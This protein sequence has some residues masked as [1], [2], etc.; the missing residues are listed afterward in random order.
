MKSI[1]TT[2]FYIVLISEP[3]PSKSS[4]MALSRKIS[5]SSIHVDLFILFHSGSGQLDRTGT[6]AE[7]DAQKK[8]AISEWPL[9]GLDSVPLFSSPP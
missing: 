4:L 1:L 8:R 5:E 9:T 7:G 6:R 3:T 2:H